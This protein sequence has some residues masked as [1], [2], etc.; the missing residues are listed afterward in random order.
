[1]RKRCLGR[2]GQPSCTTGGR[3]AATGAENCEVSEKVNGSEA[4]CF[5]PHPTK[6]RQDQIGDA[7]HQLCLWEGAVFAKNAPFC[8]AYFVGQIVHH[9]I[10]EQEPVDLFH[11]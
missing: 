10:G 4:P 2:D 8:A 3:G 7:D 11:A 1:M 6:P 9:E 5:N